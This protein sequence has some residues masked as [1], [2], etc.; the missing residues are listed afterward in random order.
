M[1]EIQN[2]SYKIQKEA[3]GAVPFQ[4]AYIGAK[5][6]ETGQEMI[7]TSIGTLVHY[8]AGGCWVLRWEEA[9]PW[10][11]EELAFTGEICMSTYFFPFF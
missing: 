10:K 8:M 3:R 1:E 5:P 7:A 11:S 9:F 6:K 4:N 2:Y